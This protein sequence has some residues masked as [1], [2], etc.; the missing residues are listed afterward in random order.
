M[1]VFLVSELNS[2]WKKKSLAISEVERQVSVMKQTWNNKEAQ[3]R[4]ERDK[5]LEAARY[6]VLS[7]DSPSRK[8]YCLIVCDVI[9]FRIAV[10]RIRSM[11][12]AFRQQLDVKEQQHT[13]ELRRAQHQAQHDVDAANKRV[14]P[15]L[16]R[17]LPPF[18]DIFSSDFYFASSI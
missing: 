11:D 10:D 17:P 16:P 4:E 9:R 5:A 14:S 7:L 18:P 12:D 2:Q 3:L 1:V 6:P 13:A 8:Q 15:A